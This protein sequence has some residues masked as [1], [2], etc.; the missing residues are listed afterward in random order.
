MESP[1]VITASKPP[2]F[3]PGPVIY[4]GPGACCH[5]LAFLSQQLL[6]SWTKGVTPDYKAWEARGWRDSSP[7]GEKQI[8][9]SQ[10][11]PQKR[12]CLYEF[13]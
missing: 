4:R 1:Y 2:D 8:A 13:I 11:N 5:T 7:V 9:K 3:F 6:Q 10:H 12:K